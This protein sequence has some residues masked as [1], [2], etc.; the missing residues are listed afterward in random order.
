MRQ[1]IVM[2]VLAVVLAA[3]AWRARAD[4][5]SAVVSADT[6]RMKVS[7]AKSRAYAE[8]VEQYL[9][10]E[11]A[12]PDGVEW[13]VARCRFAS[14]YVDEE[15]DGIE[16]AS[17]DLEVCLD[18]LRKRWAEA[19]E[20]KVFLFEQS[21]GEA[22]IVE[23]EALLATSADWPDAQRRDL[24]AMLAT[25]Y[26][27]DKTTPATARAGELALQ[28]VD[29]GDETQV[30][31]A[32][33]HLV[34]LGD[35]EAAAG[36]LRDS[37]PATNEWQATQRVEAALTL[38]DQQAARV[39][40]Q[41]HQAADITIDA[42]VAARAHLRA[43]DAPKAAVLLAERKS[44]FETVRSVKFDVA[45][46]SDDYATA[47]AQVDAADLAHLGENLQ[48]FAI[49]VRHAP[50]TLLQ[51]PMVLE[52][53]LV[54]AFV[55]ICL[56][57][58]AM[59]LIPVHYRGLVRR[60]KGRIPTALFASIGLRHAWYGMFVLIA[61]PLLVAAI[62]EPTSLAATFN[63]DLDDHAA[64]ARVSFWGTAA[65]L[66]VLA[67]QLLRL[68]RESLVD[69]R[70][71]LRYLAW[72]VVSWL[73]LLA[74]AFAVSAVNRALAVPTE[75]EQTRMVQALV[76]SGTATL[77]VFLTFMLVAVLVPILEEAIFRGLLLGG[78]AR[79]ISFGWANLIQALLFAAIHDDPPRFVWY[80]ALGLVAGVLVKRSGSLF[81]A[82]ALHALQN[83]F[84]FFL[85]SR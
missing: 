48:R 84:A 67:P 34:S 29:L 44:E 62:V 40:L 5:G 73:A 37:P 9:A 52:A 39:E 54:L 61:I 77:G 71:W 75:T 31:A 83:G 10:A 8:Q 42:L 25:R 13:T 19:P 66:L 45:M 35:H 32:A 72:V 47:A 14:T 16:S 1:F 63:G 81:P 70:Q 59:L 57:L 74:I 56:L 78:M 27:Y 58:P 21:W 11:Q 23:G 15:Y 51:S 64:L 18:D 28:A 24:L 69:H 3:P 7:A 50:A 20:A 82:I 60:V 36:L 49:V 4:S 22:S 76:D 38:D 80:A 17:A 55:L 46:A 43:G 12:Q 2:F 30:A 41:R 79:H 6:A 85:L 65:C 68:G 53:A 26:S 33:R